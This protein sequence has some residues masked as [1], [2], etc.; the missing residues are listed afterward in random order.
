MITIGFLVMCS[1]RDLELGLL[2]DQNAAGHSRLLHIGISRIW[3]AP[4]GGFGCGQGRHEARV[5]DVPEE[6]AGRETLR[7][8]E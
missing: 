5:R 1:A 7:I 2:R 8:A 3:L 6:T 4:V